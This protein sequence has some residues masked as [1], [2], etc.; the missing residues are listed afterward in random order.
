[1]GDSPGPVIRLRGA[2]DLEQSTF[3]LKD[4]PSWRQP[5]LRRVR[6]WRAL[7][8]LSKL[9]VAREKEGRPTEGHVEAQVDSPANASATEGGA[10]SNLGLDGRDAPRDREG[11][12][13]QGRG[14]ADW[15]AAGD[16]A[17]QRTE[18]RSARRKGWEPLTSALRGMV[19]GALRLPE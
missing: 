9:P 1:M 18:G 7:Q 4:A 14:P 8:R 5:R 10:S 16:S 3:K 12:G 2:G 19:S 17:V 15:H 11:C 13:L 6:Q